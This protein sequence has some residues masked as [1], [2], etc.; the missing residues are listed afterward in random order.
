ML[1]IKDYSPPEFKQSFYGLV[2][3][4]PAFVW[5]ATLSTHRETKSSI[6]FG[7][8]GIDPILWTINFHVCVQLN[9]GK[10][11]SLRWILKVA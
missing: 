11:V 6:D 5:I 2:A 3:I 10:K 1:G 9:Y 8:S 4:K 7:G